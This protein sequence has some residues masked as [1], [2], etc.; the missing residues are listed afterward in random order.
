MLSLLHKNFATIAMLAALAMVLSVFSVLVWAGKITGESAAATAL[1]T[2]TGT[3]V[4]GIAGFSM[5]RTSD[6]SSVQTTGAVQV[7]KSE[8]Q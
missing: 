7:S 8:T 3:I 4:G 5:R 2:S 1:L 6:T